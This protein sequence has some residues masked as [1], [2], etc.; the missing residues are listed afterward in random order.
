V[1]AA[2]DIVAARALHTN[3]QRMT[4]GAW[5]MNEA[6]VDKVIITERPNGWWVSV[7]HPG[8]HKEHHGPYVDHELA[9][10]EAR[11]FSD[12]IEIIQS[13]PP[14]GHHLGDPDSAHPGSAP[15]AEG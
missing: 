1:D 3:P 12:N 7:E 10:I 5:A 8:G 4:K 2:A 9:E 15:R 6:D 11:T 14:P 13:D